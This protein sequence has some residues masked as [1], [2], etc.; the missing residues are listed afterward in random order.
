MEEP[1]KSLS[2]WEKIIA[3]IRG[4]EFAADYWQ[5]GARRFGKV[6][7][8]TVLHP[9]LPYSYDSPSGPPRPVFC[10]E[11]AKDGECFHLTPD[12]GIGFLPHPLESLAEF[13]SPLLQNARSLYSAARDVWDSPE[14]F[15]EIPLSAG[16]KE[17]ISLALKLSAKLGA[18]DDAISL[19]F[20]AASIFTTT[21]LATRYGKNNHRGKAFSGSSSKYPVWHDVLKYGVARYPHLAPLPLLAKLGMEQISISGVNCVTVPAT[22]TT[23]S[24]VGLFTPLEFKRFG[25]MVQAIRAKAGKKR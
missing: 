18:N 6:P 11:P 4:H 12:F 1:P 14:A 16:Q 9:G 17:T 2:D 5:L 3:S 20:L 7:Y 15:P 13:G 22:P 19:V 21:D 25:E 10:P 8:K 23:R 24:F